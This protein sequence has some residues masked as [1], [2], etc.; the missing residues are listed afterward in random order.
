M[1]R[2]AAVNSLE[3]AK[4]KWPECDLGLAENLTGKKFG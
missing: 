1:A 3:E 4:I 2:I